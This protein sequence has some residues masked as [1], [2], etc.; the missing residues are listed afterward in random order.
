MDQPTEGLTCLPDLSLPPPK[1]PI[2]LG[3]LLYPREMLE[4]VRKPS[5]P[6][7]MR[8]F[9]LGRRTQEK[10]LFLANKAANYQ[11]FRDQHDHLRRYCRTCSETTSMVRTELDVP[12]LHSHH[13]SL[14]YRLNAQTVDR[15][16]NYHC[17][18]C[19]EGWHSYLAGYRY[20]VLATSSTLNGWQGRRD[21][22]GYRGDSL[23]L[24]VVAIP[25]GWVQDVHHAVIA[26]YRL[27]GHP[28]DLIIVAG[29]NNLMA[30]QPP[31]LVMDELQRFKE[32]VLSISGSSVGIC[33]L[34]MPPSMSV[35]PGD[36]GHHRENLTSDLQELNFMI[37]E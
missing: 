22:N 20:P 28:I 30:G 24:D 8:I 7:Q 15:W 36:Q 6:S 1:P 5:V 26:E 35:L 13:S 33:T 10:R 16:G 14:A 2:G 12:V 29:L 11:E 37:R 4:F 25:G 9:S 3:T 17:I 18:T 34:P 27:L 31:I 19:E 21:L 32:D 23:H